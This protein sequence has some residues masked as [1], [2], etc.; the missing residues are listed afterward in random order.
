MLEELGLL[1][2]L[3]IARVGKGFRKDF[4]HFRNGCSTAAIC[5]NSLMCNRDAVNAVNKQE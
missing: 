3:M 1:T 5:A 4:R 2:W